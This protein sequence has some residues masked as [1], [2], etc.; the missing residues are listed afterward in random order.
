MLLCYY[1]QDF[2]V[3]ARTGCCWYR[4]SAVEKVGWVSCLPFLLVMSALLCYS[5]LLLH[6]TL[7]TVSFHFINLSHSPSCYSVW[8]LLMAGCVCDLFQN[9]LIFSYR[10]NI[11]T[12]VLSWCAVYYQ[13]MPKQRLSA[14]Y[15]FIYCQGF[16]GLTK[17]IMIQFR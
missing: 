9:F 14:T 8:L 15:Y 2:T 6:P 10:Q 5:C 17:R 12:A 1:K 3:Y 7:A 13:S 4:I 16:V 11:S